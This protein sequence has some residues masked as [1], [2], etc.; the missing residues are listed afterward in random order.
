LTRLKGEAKMV[1]TRVTR[2][3]WEE[4]DKD[5]IELSNLARQLELYNRTEGKSQATITWYNLALKQLLE[6]LD[7]RGNPI[8]LGQ[9]GEVEIRQFILY[10]QERNRWQEN[11]NEKVLNIPVCLEADTFTSILIVGGRASLARGLVLGASIMA[12]TTFILGSKII[13]ANADLPNTAYLASQDFRYVRN[14]KQSSRLFNN[15]TNNKAGYHDGTQ[16]Y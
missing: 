5:S 1:Y 10:L 13:R 2:T 12:K 16:L 15:A 4:V 3:R 6:F 11:D 14:I 8:I 7:G 9:L